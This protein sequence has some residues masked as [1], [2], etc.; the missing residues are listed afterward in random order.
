MTSFKNLYYII[1]DGNELE[2]FELSVD[3][4]KF[5]ELNENK[6]DMYIDSILVKFCDV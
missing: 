3:P 2:Y 1:N 6:T 5:T 4:I